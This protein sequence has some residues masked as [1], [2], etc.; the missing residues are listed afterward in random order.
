[1][2]RVV[3]ALR[4]CPAIEGGYLLHWS[5]ALVLLFPLGVPLGMVALLLWFRVPHLAR[6][7]LEVL[8]LPLALSAHLHS[9]R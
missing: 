1:M 6:E 9:A 3:P 7:K 5:V 4:R 8:L 2:P